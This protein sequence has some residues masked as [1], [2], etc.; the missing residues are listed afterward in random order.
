MEIIALLLFIVVVIFA[1]IILNLLEEI[2]DLKV[3]LE[4][5]KQY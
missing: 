2:Y 5:K 3:E 4:N 1:K